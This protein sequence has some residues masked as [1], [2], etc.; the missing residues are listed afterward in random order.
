MTKLSG[1]ITLL[2]SFAFFKSIKDDA[3]LCAS[4]IYVPFH[5]PNILSVISLFFLSLSGRSTMRAFPQ[6]KFCSSLAVRWLPL[7]VWHLRNRNTSSHLGKN[8]IVFNL[9]F[10]M[11]YFPLNSFIILNPLWNLALQKVRNTVTRTLPFI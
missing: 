3:A 6:K 11:I 5:L 2:T 9:L 10:M 4:Y 7:A 1:K 8:N